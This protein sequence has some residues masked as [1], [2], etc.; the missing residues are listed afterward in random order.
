MKTEIVTRVAELI[1]N[2]AKVSK[3]KLDR[4]RESKTDSVELSQSAAKLADAAKET[5]GEY[6]KNRVEKVKRLEQLVQ[7]GHY[8][9]N[10]EMVD[11][12]AER[13]I[14]LL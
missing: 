13:I 10:D 14:E 8:K 4:E 12:I 1:R 5:S 11:Q 6:E 7:G 3:S 2:P 9:M